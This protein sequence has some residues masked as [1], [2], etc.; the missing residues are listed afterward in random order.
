MG[1]S[2]RYSTSKGGGRSCAVAGR[3]ISS[4]A[5]RRAVCSGVSEESSALPPGRA[6]WPAN[7]RRE[8][9]RSVRTTRRDPFRS[10]KRRRRTAARR[11]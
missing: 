7:V 3:P 9:E 8:E 10:A 2:Q 5:S 11:V 4:S 1:N 6:T